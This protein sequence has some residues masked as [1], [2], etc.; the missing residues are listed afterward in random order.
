MATLSWDLAGQRFYESGVDRGV[1]YPSN[2]PGVAWNG[3]L[4]VDEQTVGGEPTPRYIDGVKFLNEPAQHDF[5]AT[6]EA[7]TYP[8]EF[9]AVD[10]MHTTG[11]GLFYDQQD[12]DFFD[13]SYRTKIGNDLEGLEYGYRIHLVYN[14]M[15]APTQRSNQTIGDN[16]EALTF[17]WD[18]TTKPVYIASRRPTSHLIVDS[19]KTNPWILKQIEELL[20]GVGRTAA[21]MPSPDSVITI[22]DDWARFEIERAPNTGLSPLL[23]GGEPD[24]KGDIF[25]GL[26]SAPSDSRL[27][28]APGDSG[29]YTLE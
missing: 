17:S 28:K 25:R 21:K 22:F 1:F 15:A 18:L 24:L 11:S 6:L 26:Y 16:P 12:K 27:E 23:L 29:L 8:D 2:G 9:A 19:T 5:M 14:A 7:Y 10:G 3:L 4:G 13:L 20:Y